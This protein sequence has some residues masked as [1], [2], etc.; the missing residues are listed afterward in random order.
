MKWNLNRIGAWTLCLVSFFY[1]TILPSASLYSRRRPR[2]CI[3]RS[4]SSRSSTSITSALGIREQVFRNIYHELSIHILN[5]CFRKYYCFLYYDKN[6]TSFMRLYLFNKV[7]LVSIT[8]LS[9][10]SSQTR[11]DVGYPW[12]GNATFRKIV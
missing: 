1:S 4:N 11:T 8:T 12:T 9:K 2:R 6:Y 5:Q 10:Q 3:R 7:R